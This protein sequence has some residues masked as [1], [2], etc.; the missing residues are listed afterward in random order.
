MVLRVNRRYNSKREGEQSCHSRKNG[1]AYHPLLL[2]RLGLAPSARQK[3]VKAYQHIQMCPGTAGW[4]RPPLKQAGLDRP[5]L[6]AQ[7]RAQIQIEVPVLQ[8][9]ENQR[10]ICRHLSASRRTK[11]NPRTGRS[12]EFAREDF[13]SSRHEGT[14][15]RNGAN[16]LRIGTKKR[17]ITR[18]AEPLL[19]NNP[20]EPGAANGERKAYGC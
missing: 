8:L 20:T 10:F 7:S 3:A 9:T 5:Q 16:Q 1:L 19:L 15:A 13:C 14:P 6:Y 11:V 12:S 18:Q 17:I 2:L 4:S